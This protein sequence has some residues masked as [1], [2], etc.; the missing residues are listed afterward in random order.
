[1]NRHIPPCKDCICLPACLPKT[2]EY[3][4]AVMTNDLPVVIVNTL[5]QECH[6]IRDYIHSHP[7]HYCEYETSYMSHV[8]SIMG[9]TDETS[10]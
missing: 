5:M 8:L 6:L 2:H 3:K 10:I 7:R 4:Q 9:L 1:M